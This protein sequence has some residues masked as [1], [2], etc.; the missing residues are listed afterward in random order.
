M[1]TSPHPDMPDLQKAFDF[2]DKDLQANHN[3]WITDEQ[4]A[5]ALTCASDYAWLASA[6]WALFGILALATLVSKLPFAVMISCLIVNIP[7]TLAGF[8]WR[9]RTLSNLNQSQVRIVE[10]YS[11]LYFNKFKHYSLFHWKWRNPE[12]HGSVRCFL[13][14]QGSAGVKFNITIPQYHALRD[15]QPYRVFYLPA[16]KHILSIEPLF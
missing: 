9:R 8:I 2:T 14:I 10:G 5:K 16:V 3:S 15:L 4:K 7:L 12:T 11:V 1:T 6:G 13:E